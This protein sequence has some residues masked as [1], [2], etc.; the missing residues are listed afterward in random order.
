MQVVF[1]QAAH[2]SAVSAVIISEGLCFFHASRAEM[3]ELYL[4][5]YTA[6]HYP[7]GFLVI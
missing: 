3:L 6:A 4:Q 2:P 7:L 1:L 5:M